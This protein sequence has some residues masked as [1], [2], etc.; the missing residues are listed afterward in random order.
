VQLV[1]GR[2]ATVAEGMI[3]VGGHFP[4]IQGVTSV[5]SSVFRGILTEKRAPISEGYN[6]K[7]ILKTMQIS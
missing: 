7:N 4:R 3:Y 5:V 1:V 2:A 6:F